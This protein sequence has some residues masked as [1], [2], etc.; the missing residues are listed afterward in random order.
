[1][2]MTLVNITQNIIMWRSHA[3]G[4]LVLSFFKGVLRIDVAPTCTTKIILMEMK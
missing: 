3:G 4:S 1:M 2:A